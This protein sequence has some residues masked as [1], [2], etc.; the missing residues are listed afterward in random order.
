MGAY[1]K[2]Y[3]NGD[4]HR[5]RAAATIEKAS[6][7]DHATFRNH[8]RALLRAGEIKYHKEPYSVTYYWRPSEEE[9]KEKP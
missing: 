9:K 3:W 1:K 6:G 8:I 5:E 4:N 7:L 2:H